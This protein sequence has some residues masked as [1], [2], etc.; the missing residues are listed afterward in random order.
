MESQVNDYQ[1]RQ[2]NLLY[3]F[4][5]T[6]VNNLVRLSCKNSYG[7]KYSRDFSVYEINSI[8]PMFSV[9][10][11]EQDAINFI[12][13][14][15]NVHKVGVREESGVV[16]IIFYVANKGLL[17]S[18]EIPLGEDGK[19]TFESN[20]QTYENTNYS[21]GGDNTYGQNTGISTTDY[22]GQNF[23]NIGS[24]NYQDNNQYTQENYD[25]YGISNSYGNYG[26]NS[27][28]NDYNTNSYQYSYNQYSTTTDNYNFSGYDNAYQTN[29]EATFDLN[30]LT[31]TNNY[32][33]VI[34]NETYS[35]PTI[36]PADPIETTDNENKDK[37]QIETA[38][39]PEKAQQNEKESQSQTLDKNNAAQV[40]I[41]PQKE[42]TQ[43][44]DS[45][46][47]SEI[48]KLKDEA[49]EAKA[50]RAQL[51][52]LTPLR[53]QFEQMSVLKGQL[54]EL[55]SLR[56]KAAELN[57]V[58]AQLNELNELREQ[59][60]QMNSLKKQLEE[61]E[62]L[63]Q[64]ADNAD[65][66]QKKIEEL[67]KANLEYQ[68]EL[69][70]V[71]ASQFNTPTKP[72]SPFKQ[73]SKGLESKEIK[74]EEKQICVK[75]DII[76][77]TSELE[78]L[79][80]KINKYNKKLTLNLIYKASADSDQASAFHEK[81]DKAKSTIVLVETDKGK[82][83]GG[84]TTCSWSGDCVDKKDEDAFIFSLDK[85]KTYDNIP[86]DDAIGCYPKFGPI[87]LGCQ[88]RIYDNAFKR[89]GTTFEKGLNFDTDEDYEL[90]GGE[91]I[92]NVK[93]I[94]V[95]EVIPQ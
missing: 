32:E 90:T 68:R 65:N 45:L 5:T 55:N 59:V 8:D 85:M 33:G 30:S 79:T 11:S 43:E 50:L 51:A 19:E 29:G 86:G 91:R 76:Q 67:E 31:T 93:E 44:K 13:K 64:K 58:K 22:S 71:K 12:D 3:V 60:N 56:E 78:L 72:K 47:A 15:L 87:F 53:Q 52:E 6:I 26:M 75:G 82:R 14:A 16:K 92:F 70:E 28:G 21:Y 1:L 40:P 24:Y 95:Y 4:S 54:D 36:T 49:A 84:F 10:N 63:K 38:T 39:T 57:S 81:C 17:N 80:R 88:I 62:I 9:I 42:S 35:K 83:F 48:Q 77:D 66:L 74:F 7:K 46:N 25:T 23:E 69:R 34:N 27:F 37:S 94:E 2:G 61:I 18:V 89:G 41:T 73:E 20:Q